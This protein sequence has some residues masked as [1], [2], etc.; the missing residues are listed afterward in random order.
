MDPNMPATATLVMRYG[1]TPVT[2]GAVGAYTVLN[3][4]SLDRSEGFLDRTR[5]YIRMLAFFLAIVLLI[6]YILEVDQFSDTSTIY[7]IFLLLIFTQCV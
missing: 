1:D 5:R 3:K 7:G 4:Q 6:L 2:N